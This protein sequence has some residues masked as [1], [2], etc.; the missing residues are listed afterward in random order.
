MR[1]MNV[2]QFPAGAPEPLGVTPRGNGVNVAVFSANASAIEFCLFEHD[3]EVR[4][5]RL[6]GRTGDVFHDYIP[7][8]P[9]GARYGLRAHGPWHPAEGHCFNPAKL[10]IDPY[11][12]VIDRPFA[13]HHSMFGFR[14]GSSQDA[15]ARDDTDSA[16]FMPKAIV[17]RSEPPGMS[18]V[19]ITPWVKTVVYELHVRGFTARHPAIPAPTRGRFAGLAHP[20][21]IEHLVKLGITAVEIMPAA[22]WIEERHLA[23]RGLR[24]YWG[25]N[26]VA[27]MVP[28]PVLAPDGWDE[29]RAAVTALADAGIETI[30]DV[31]LNHT[32]EGDALGPT[33]SLRGLDNA[34]YFRSQPGHPWRYAD[35]TGCGNALALDRPAPLRLAMD[36]LR[37]WAKRA[38]VHGFRFDLATIMGR[39]DD[40]FD[41]MAPLLSA[42]AQDPLLRDLKLIAEPW[43]V[44]PGGYRLGE[45]PSAWSEWNDRFRDDVRSFWRGDPGKLGALATRL[46]GSS[47]IFATRG[48]PARSINFVVAH[49]GFTLADLVSFTNKVNAANGEDNHDGTD[50]NFSWNNGVEGPSDDTAVIAAR[51]RDQRALLATLILARGTPMLT[52]GAEF[53]QSQHGN[54]NAYAQD[55][56]TAWLDWDNAD[57]DLIAWTRHL[58]RLRRDYAPLHSGRFLTGTTFDMSLLPDV[59]W[60]DPAGQ[61]MAPET[62]QSPHGD[63]LTMT[64]AC[65]SETADKTDRIALIFHR[66]GAD[67]VVVLPG[68][69]EGYVWRIVAESS[70]AEPHDADLSDPPDLGRY[71]AEKPVADRSVTVSPRSIIVLSEQP[72]GSRPNVL[73]DPAVLSRLA[74]AAGIA[75]EWWDVEGRRTIVSDDTRRALL[76]SMRIP[77]RTTGEARD[78]LRQLSEDRD[79]RPLPHALVARRDESAALRLAIDPA[80]DRRAMWLMIEQEDGEKKQI[81]LGSDDGGLADITA[82]DGLPGRV[83]SVTLPPL[84]EGRHR[85]WREDAPNCICHLAVVPRR[86][87]LPDAIMQ[88]A[89][90]FG[91]SAQLYALRRTGDQ[92]IGDFSTLAMLAEQAARAG[93]GTISINPLHMLF[94]GE[95]ERAS[96]YHPSDRRFLDPIYL[97]VRAEQ[98]AT[99]KPND[100]LRPVPDF[101]SGDEHVRYTE[102]WS[103]KRAELERQ[104]VAF[105]ESERANSPATAEFQRFI[106]DGGQELWRFATFQAIAENRPGTSWKEWPDGLNRSGSPEVETFARA[107]ADRVRFHQYLQFRADQQLANAAAKANAHG[108]RFGLFGDL[109]VGAAPD[110]AEAWARAD[111]L[112][113]GAWIGAPP[114]PLAADGQNWHLPPPLP[115]SLARDGYA[116]YAAL[117]KANMHHAGV[118]RIDHAMGLSRLFWIP[119][120]ARG[121]DGA[122]VS[123]PFADMVGQIA[124]ESVRA[125]CMV[126]GEDL[127]TVP[128]GFRPVM[129]EASIL[130]YRVLL[131][132]HDDDRFKPASGYPPRSVACVTTHDLPP[133][134]GWLEDVDILERG[135]LGLL[136]NTA[137]ATERRRNDRQ[138]L[139]ELL[140]AAGYLAHAD[141]AELPVD[142]IIAAAHAF[143]ASTPADLVLVQAEDL[144]GARVA[145]NLPGTDR[146]RSNWR[147]RIPVAVEDLISSTSAREIL[148][149]IRGRGRG[150][151]DQDST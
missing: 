130:G 46:S 20:A 113:D 150:T 80:L 123:Y 77:N 132:E 21:A 139:I 136:P 18:R 111:E 47:D 71:H 86:C 43:D 65:P 15:L 107:K 81:R 118:L 55:N 133:L 75:P 116:S 101:V 109:A 92:G 147:L 57:R 4:R 105:R 97:D 98:D 127:G 49:D 131:L 10:L 89:K 17:T 50:A 44:G 124:L 148:D 91:I 84:P 82:I 54:N 40:R 37:F 145:V 25:Y 39:R 112:A 122:Y 67:A 12:S 134:A 135:T 87:F 85:I 34:T 99:L 125:R 95:R 151:A 110:G 27:L 149:A 3:Q 121:A 126:V 53:G 11:A 62:W 14:A 72:R 74:L 83:W 56:S 26:P 106:A 78:S 5:S 88:G 28:D 16:P 51:K 31:V 29:V 143:V 66:G 117:I 61:L 30:L 48:D 64:L 42:I 13:L 1:W 68:S 19:P 7:D 94:P 33:L 146:E 115:L 60:H 59:E 24:N 120:G 76:T 63:T 102:V 100:R 138:A 129:T 2:C 22:A 137:A 142:A 114:D 119:D 32:G 103:F 69:R 140:V 58:L 141:A 35:D 8:V 36:S 45:F 41:P 128:E 96:P 52:M 9:L 144:A 70:S 79:R 90:R 108:L 38:G 104:F 73:P 93:A 6:R 23:A